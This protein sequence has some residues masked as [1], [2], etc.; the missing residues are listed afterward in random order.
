MMRYL[1]LMVFALVLGGCK[2]D[3]TIRA[4]A[5]YPEIVDLKRGKHVVD[6]PVTFQLSGG[7]RLGGQLI[8]ANGTAWSACN[9]PNEFKENSLALS[10][11]GYNLTSPALDVMNIS[12][13]PF[14]VTSV[15]YR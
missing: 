12:P 11:T 5:C 7:L 9:L 1:L 13:V 14:E 6:V 3:K 10:V 2:R 4:V 15:K 8:L